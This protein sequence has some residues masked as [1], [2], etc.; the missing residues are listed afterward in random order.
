[1]KI[2]IEALLEIAK[3]DRV[4]LDKDS[5]QDLR[6]RLR[7]VVRPRNQHI[8]IGRLLARLAFE[9]FLTRVAEGGTGFR[10]TMPS[11]EDP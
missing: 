8:P 11:V 9:G 1:M 7:P 5:V 2:L 6:V 4:V 10:L 3:A